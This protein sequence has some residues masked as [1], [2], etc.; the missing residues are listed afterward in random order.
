MFCGF[1]FIEAYIDDL[2]IIT[3]VDWYDQLN[4]LGILIQ[5]VK[6]NGINCNIEKPFFGKSQMEYLGFWVMWEGIC[7][8]NKK[9]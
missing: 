9:V 7:P 5:K 6:E 1:E 8:V 4:K 3:R 2:L